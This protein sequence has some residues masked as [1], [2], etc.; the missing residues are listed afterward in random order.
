MA[1]LFASGYEY[2]DGSRQA[3]VVCNLCLFYL[4]K[5]ENA[6]VPSSLQM[7][8]VLM[9]DVV[10]SQGSCIFKG[11]FFSK[12]LTFLVDSLL[13]Q[14][15]DSKLQLRDDQFPLTCQMTFEFTQQIM[16][17]AFLFLLYH[18]DESYSVF[19]L[20]FVFDLRKKLYCG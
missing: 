10:S 5:K 18:I 12:L 20:F 9:R 6:L 2:D 3:P 19:I 16:V 14:K 15:L 7:F 17:F 13:Q 4:K 8:S 1:C 11:Q